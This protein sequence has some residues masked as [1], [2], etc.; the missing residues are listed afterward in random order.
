MI[1]GLYASIFA[2]WLL[3]LIYGVIHKRMTYK[4]GLGDGGIKDLE[5]SIR[6]HGN[7]IEIVPFSLLLLFLLEYQGLNEVLLHLFGLSLILARGFHA[8]GLSK[9]PYRSTGRMV[10]TLLSHIVILLSAML[11]LYQFIRLQIGL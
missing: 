9:S 4:V 1:T 11:L 3:V 10:G 6:V 8:Y 7:F 2:L 5:Q